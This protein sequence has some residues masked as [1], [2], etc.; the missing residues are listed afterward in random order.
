[1]TKKSLLRLST[2]HNADVCAKMVGQVLDLIP[3]GRSENFNFSS[4]PAQNT[5]KQSGRVRAQGVQHINL[6]VA[7]DFFELRVFRPRT[8]G[9]L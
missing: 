1:M 5:C 4:T 7:T 8:L 9:K 2:I 3:C 6:L